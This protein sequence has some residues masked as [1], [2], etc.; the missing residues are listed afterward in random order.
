[1]DRDTVQ[2]DWEDGSQLA[3]LTSG[4]DGLK[5]LMVR[6]GFNANFRKWGDLT[7]YAVLGAGPQDEERN[8]EAKED[9]HE[10][11]GMAD[12]LQ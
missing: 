9:G 3:S 8:F 2:I 10:E 4:D 11:D 12:H 1:V 5:A 7:I 6:I